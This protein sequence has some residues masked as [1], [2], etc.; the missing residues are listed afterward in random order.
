MLFVPTL[1]NNV[2]TKPINNR[3]FTYIIYLATGQKIRHLLNLG[4][5][6]KKEK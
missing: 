4:L 5:S 2:I 6:E 3:R 1:I